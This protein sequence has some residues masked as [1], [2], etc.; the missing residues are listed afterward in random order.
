MYN[1]NCVKHYSV[2]Q[3]TLC[4]S[5]GESSLHGITTGVPTG[6][7]MQSIANYL[8]FDISVRIHSDACAAIGIARRR[9]FGKIQHLDVKDPWVQ[10]N[11]RDRCV[12]LVNIVGNE[13]P[14]DV[15][16]KYV[17][18]DLLNKMREHIG[19]AHMDGRASAAPELPKEQ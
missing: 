19:M 17:A 9:G 4:L 16:R 1:G 11:I 5:S 3:S 7:G 15:L 2:T 10:Q 12:D 14:A 8:E 13:N 18:A 6:F